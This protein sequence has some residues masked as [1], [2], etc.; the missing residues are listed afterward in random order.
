MRI[1]GIDP[2]IAATGYGLIEVQG[3]ALTCIEYGCIET[4]KEETPGNRLLLLEEGIGKVLNDFRPDVVGIETLFFAKNI[5]TAMPVS[6]AR[7]V[8]LLSIARKKLPVFEFSPP[9]I[10]SAVAGHGRA[11]KKQIQRM[12]Q[13]ILRLSE[14]PKPDDAADGLA[15]AITCSLAIKTR[16]V[17]TS[18]DFAWPPCYDSM[19]GLK[20]SCK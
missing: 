6:E 11:D 14:L 16:Y 3:S 20:R 12:V 2:G 19:R 4:S 18:L 17:N 15:C 9:Q 10:K 7:G 8:I 5:K 1:L 13:H